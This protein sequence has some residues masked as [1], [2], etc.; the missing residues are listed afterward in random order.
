ME[1]INQRTKNNWEA[2]CNK[3]LINSAYDHFLF[4]EEGL[5]YGNDFYPW[6][7][8]IKILNDNK[9]TK[10]GD[11]LILV[12]PEYKKGDMSPSPWSN[13]RLTGKNLDLFYANK[14]GKYLKCID[15]KENY[16]TLCT[17]TA[18]CSL[19]KWPEIEYMLNHP[20]TQITYKEYCEKKVYQNKIAK[21]EIDKVELIGNF[22]YHVFIPCDYDSKMRL[23]LV[24]VLCLIG[25]V[26]NGKEVLW[27][28]FILWY[29][30]E[31]ILAFVTKN[32]R[33]G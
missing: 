10:K 15:D 11:V 27:A 20:G 3:F 29:I 19:E 31:N 21:G 4:E 1:K 6:G 2:Y 33:D 5:K 7:S 23:L 16:K 14:Y 8:K 12:K 24:I 9:L 32:N 13:Q 28:V 25:S 18:I 22:L 30:A 26:F 17:N